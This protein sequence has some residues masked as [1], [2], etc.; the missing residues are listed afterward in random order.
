MS[1][2]LKI[3]IP[4]AGVGTRLRP[5]TY[6]IPKPLLPV[7]GKEMLAHV[8]DPLV[9]L[10]PEEVIFVVGYLGDKIVEYVK[11]KYKF[12][13]TFVEQNDLLGLG[14]AVN[15]ALQKI[16]SGRLMIILGDTIARTDFAD[17][18][19]NGDAIGL[20]KVR[21]PRRFGIAVVENGKIVEFEEKP[22]E[23]RSDLAIIGLYYFDN[24]DVLK[25]HI[26]K[27]I[28]SGKT[29]R[30][31]VQLTDALDLM[32]RGGRTFRPYEVDGWYDCGKK[33]TMLST[34]RELLLD[35]SESDDYAGSV[36]IPPVYI[37]PSAIIEDSVIG[38]YVSIMDDTEIKR[39]VIRNSIISRKAVVEDSL[40]DESLIGESANI[41]GK[42]RILN[43]GDSSEVK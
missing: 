34:N 31:E 14:F 1:T 15:V 29:T 39:S 35:S 20:K 42:F 19:S 6:S 22:S 11:Q 38:P 10:D 17:F 30:G 21:D 8:V 16:N 23:P 36:I 25:E 32:V 40:L 2:D 7:A 9:E 13:A 28:K 12:K 33:E 37:A 24:S 3:V 4:V 18:I 26:E 43:A 41:R 27:L 5:H